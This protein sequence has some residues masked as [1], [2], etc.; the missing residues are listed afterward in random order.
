MADNDL[1]LALK[2]SDTGAYNE[3]VKA[4]KGWLNAVIHRQLRDIELTEETVQEVLL[5]LWSKRQELRDD[6]NIANWLY[7]VAINLCRNENRKKR[8]YTLPPPKQTLACPQ[9]TILSRYRQYYIKKAV[10]KL[11]T[12]QREVFV[13]AQLDGLPYEKVASILDIPVGTVKSRMFH[14]LS[15]LR[16]SLEKHREVL[17]HEL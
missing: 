6:S 10:N 2:E 11:P 17:L 14:A 1:V 4:N 7:T 5:R 12:G 8:I 15:K 13:L 3:I 9:Q 16:E